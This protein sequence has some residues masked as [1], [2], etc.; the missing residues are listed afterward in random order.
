MYE[1]A[2][3][4][5]EVLNQVAVAEHFGVSRVPVREA[6]RQLQAEGLLSVEAHR[7]SA[8]DDP[9]WRRDGGVLPGPF[10]GDG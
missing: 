4:D 2:L 6:M 9:W 10:A 8:A 7:I 3:A 5:G 1:G